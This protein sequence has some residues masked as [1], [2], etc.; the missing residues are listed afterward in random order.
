MSLLDATRYRL[1]TLRRALFDR[2]AWRREMDEELDFHMELDAMQ[3]R[4]AGAADDEARRAARARFG[5]PARAREPVV[6]ATGASAVDALGQDLRFAA[7]TLRASPAYTL[8]AVLTL[9]LGVGATTAIFSVVS[10]AL[11][12]PLPFP[13]GE[14][15]VLVGEVNPKAGPGA[16]AGTVSYPNFADWQRAGRSFESMALYNEWGPS[17]TGSGDPERLRGA[18]VTAGVFDVLRVAPALGRPIVP[19]D[20]VPGAA[21]VALLADGFWRRRFGADPGVVGRALTVNGVPR[22]VVGV[23]PP[24]FRPPGELD[25]ELW[26]NNYFDSTDTRGARYLNAIARLAPGATLDGARAELRGIAARLAVAYPDIDAGWSAT[27]TPLRDAIVG[28]ARRPLLLLLGASALVLAVACANLSNLLIARGLARA[29]EFALRTALGAGRWRVVR[30]V[31]VE[32]AAL[33]L[34]GAA[35]GVALAALTLRAVMGLAPDAIRAQPVAIDLPVL[36]F[37]LAATVATG[38]LAGLAP[39]LRASRADP[40]AAHRQ[41]RERRSRDRA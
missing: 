20:N 29:R 2:A 12:R 14:R 35:A 4:H 16:R 13:E 7:R 23:L 27:A 39:A 10:A 34:L 1:G 15:I 6:D 40:H 36:A 5:H 33:S 17:L 26:G 18:L 3:H 11:L 31:L 32:S 9:A 24:G 21:P 37:A 28:D 8:V 19:A 25:A 22:T 38:L 41:R 30:Q